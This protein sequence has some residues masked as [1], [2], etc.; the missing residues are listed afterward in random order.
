MPKRSS[1]KTA[2]A[3]RSPDRAGELR[4]ALMQR[5]KLELANF[6]LDLAR[7]DTRMFRQVAARFD[8]APTTPDALVNATSL[9]IGDATY[10]DERE[11][12]RN[13]KY[14]YDAYDEIKRNFG[15]LVDSGEL[16]PAMDLSLE[17]MRDGSEQVEMSDEGLMSADIEECLKVVI[18][19]LKKCNMPADQIAN[20]CSMMLKADRVAFIAKKQLESL[21]N[22]MQLVASG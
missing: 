1:R 7:A 16:R 22:D 10:Y 17:L 5:T 11:V 18:N 12:N 13:F 21:R 19:A 4:K 6:L 9:A 3:K 8:A 20:W 14:D 15:R 2:I